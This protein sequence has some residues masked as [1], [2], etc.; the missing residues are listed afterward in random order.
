L[1]LL[2]G[3]KNDQCLSGCTAAALPH[4]PLC[5]YGQIQR[6]AKLESLKMKRQIRQHVR[7]LRQGRLFP[8]STK[9][10]ADALVLL[11]LV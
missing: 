5:F 1:L 9:V 2:L 6:A 11:S 4:L 10:H 3:G 8:L 7:N